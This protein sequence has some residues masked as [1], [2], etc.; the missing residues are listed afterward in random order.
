MANFTNNGSVEYI[1][2]KQQQTDAAA[3]YVTLLKVQ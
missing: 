3:N 1:I 2:N